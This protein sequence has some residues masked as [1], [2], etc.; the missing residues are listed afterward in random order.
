MVSE[1]ASHV[2]RVAR[3]KWRYDDAILEKACP[4]IESILIKGGRNVILLFG[5]VIERRKTPEFFKLNTIGR[6]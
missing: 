6:K 3:P 1:N 2:R 5:L 4:M